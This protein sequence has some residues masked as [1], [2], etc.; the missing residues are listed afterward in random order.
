[1]EPGAKYHMVI[2]HPSAGIKTPVFDI[3]TPKPAS[4]IRV[5][6]D[7]NGETVLDFKP[8]FATEPIKK[9]IIKYW[10][11][12][13]P[14]AVMYMETPVNIT[15]KIVLDGLQPEIDYNFMVTAKFDDGDNLASESTKIRTP[16]K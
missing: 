2:E 8:A 9:Y 11:D 5:G 7:I 6:T 12:G 1:M 10:P 4:D 13:N 15:D 3:M 14:S 16:S